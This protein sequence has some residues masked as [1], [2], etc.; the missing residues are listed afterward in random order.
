MGHLPPAPGFSTT[1][2]SPPAPPLPKAAVVGG[3]V[4]QGRV[5]PSGVNPLPPGNA[6]IGGEKEGGGY[7]PMPRVPSPRVLSALSL[8]CCIALRRGVLHAVPP[9]PGRLPR[10]PALC[11]AALCRPLLSVPHIL[12]DES[13]AYY[14]GYVLAEMSVHQT[15]TYFLSKYGHLT[16][17]PEVGR[18][19]T[20][21]YW[22][23]GHACARARVRA[24]VCVRG[25]VVEAPGVG[26]CAG[27]HGC[28]GNGVGCDAGKG[29][30]VSSSPSLHD[31][32]QS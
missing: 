26:M 4:G 5:P 13:S 24:R 29:R 11:R 18:E 23:V 8:H 10:H 19:I 9:C 25:C 30:E 14:H 12:S 7:V 16:D 21:T 31:P 32:L 20:E 1:T 6:A 17:N 22:K 15:R 2:P 28:Q 27:K 3:K